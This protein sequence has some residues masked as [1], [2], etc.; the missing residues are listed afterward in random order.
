MSFWVE[1]AEKHGKTQKIRNF[2]DNTAITC[3][4]F[5]NLDVSKAPIMSFSSDAKMS[6]FA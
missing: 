4:D 5:S 2:F 6:V 3:L 1:F